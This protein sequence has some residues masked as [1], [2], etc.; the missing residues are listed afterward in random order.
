[1]LKH[2]EWKETPDSD[3]FWFTYIQGDLTVA[4]IYTHLCEKTRIPYLRIDIIGSD[5]RYQIKE[6]D[7]PWA[8]I[9]SPSKKPVPV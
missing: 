5:E 9:T 8:K 1:M 7:G 2:K 3:G 4:Y 6:F